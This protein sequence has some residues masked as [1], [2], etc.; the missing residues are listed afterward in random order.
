MSKPSL[1]VIKRSDTRYTAY[2]ADNGRE[3]QASCEGR[4]PEEAAEN[5][6]R[7]C[8]V[9]VSRWRLMLQVALEGKLT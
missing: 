5:L 7:H 9:Q 6:V 3:Y 8:R 4:T 1:T 2:V